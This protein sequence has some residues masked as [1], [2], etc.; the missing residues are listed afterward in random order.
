MVMQI[1]ACRAKG[2]TWGVQKEFAFLT[3]AVGV[4]RAV[5][6]S[7]GVEHFPDHIVQYLLGDGTEELI[8]GDLPGV[9][10]YTGQLRVVIKHLLKMGCTIQYTWLPADGTACADMCEPRLKCRFQHFLSITQ[11]AA[12]EPTDYCQ[13]I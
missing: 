5:E 9:Q 4:L 3:L 7:A 1:A 10:I 11:R 8:A 6:A 2:T 13:P 12:S